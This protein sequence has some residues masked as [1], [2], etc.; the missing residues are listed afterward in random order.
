M[1][2]NKR[3]ASVAEMIGVAYEQVRDYIQQ[4][5]AGETVR[6]EIPVSV[7]GTG[8]RVVD[9][10]FVPHT[11]PNGEVDQVFAL[12]LDVTE[13]IQAREELR[14]TAE[15]LQRFSS[16]ATGR[17]LRMLELKREVNTLLGRLGEESRYHIPS[18]KD[19][20]GRVETHG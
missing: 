7:P 12:I 8:E 14:S 9:L 5:L 3:V 17:E 11:G 20:A 6:F 13:E 2:P 19:T 10:Q 4:A 15:R 16:L 1:Q 18:L